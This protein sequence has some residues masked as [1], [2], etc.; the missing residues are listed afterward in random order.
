MGKKKHKIKSHTIATPAKKPERLIGDR[1]SEGTWIL[2][3]LIPTIIIITVLYA[4]RANGI[5]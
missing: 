1:F 5:I 4:L 2:I 3:L